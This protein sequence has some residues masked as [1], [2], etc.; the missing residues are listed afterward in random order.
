[1]LNTLDQTLERIIRDW[2]ASEAFDRADLAV[3]SESRGGPPSFE[4]IPRNPSALSITLWVADDGAHVAFSIGGG[5]WWAD[6]IALEG[7]AVREVLSAIGSAHAGEEVRR[8]G[9]YIIGRKGY[10]ELA[11][12]RRLEYSRAGIF[13]LIPGIPWTQVH[14]EPY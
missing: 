9:R 3:K 2:I 7:T 1:M 6:H 5:S 8:I 10:V 4:V 11:P 14:Y 13:S 12:G